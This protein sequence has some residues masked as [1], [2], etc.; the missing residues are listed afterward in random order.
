MNE[1]QST[2]KRTPDN[3]GDNKLVTIKIV[4][5]YL[6]AVAEVQDVLVEAY[7]SRMYLSPILRSEPSGY[8][9]FATLLE[10]P[11]K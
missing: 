5:E 10:R 7:G 2:R 9:A 3:R 11:E 6:D 4:G 1:Y 8:H